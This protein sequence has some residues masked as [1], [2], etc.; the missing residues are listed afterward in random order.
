MGIP[1]EWLVR[2]VEYR[3]YVE[4]T[5]SAVDNVSEAV[6]N[7]VEERVKRVEAKRLPGDEVWD[8]RSI[9]AG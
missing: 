1:R 8:G 7:R 4:E 2:R 6:R 5:L 3:A 9:T